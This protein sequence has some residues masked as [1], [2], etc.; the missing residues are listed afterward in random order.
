MR[1]VNHF[2]ANR[3]HP[4]V[5]MRLE[6]GDDFLGVLELVLRRR[7]CAIDHRYLRRVDREF[8]GEAFTPRGFRFQPQPLLVAEVRKDAVD[9][10]NACGDSPGKAQ[11]PSELVCVALAPVGIIFG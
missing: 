7:E 11:R 2:P 5:G 8:A 6:G 1:P 9:R 3:Q 4:R 10:L